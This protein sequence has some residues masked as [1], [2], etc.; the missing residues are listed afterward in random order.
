MFTSPNTAY[1]TEDR[2]H[3]VTFGVAFQSSVSR[4]RQVEAELFDEAENPLHETITMTRIFISRS[5][6]SCS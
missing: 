3:Y 2:R 1:K 5:D 6:G 4:Q